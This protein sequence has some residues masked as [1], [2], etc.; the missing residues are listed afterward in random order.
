MSMDI[1]A[2]LGGPNE[3]GGN[4]SVVFEFLV[5][6]VKALW[7]KRH[8]PNFQA[9]L[10]RSL[11]G[12]LVLGWVCRAWRRFFA[13]AVEAWDGRVL[14]TPRPW[15]VVG[16]EPMVDQSV[17]DP[18]LYAVSQ[19]TIG[20]PT[21][22]RIVMLLPLVQIVEH[23]DDEAHRVVE[24]LRVGPCHPEIQATL[25]AIVTSPWSA[26][27]WNHFGGI[28]TGQYATHVD[29]VLGSFPLGF[30]YPYVTILTV[31][32]ARCT[33][34]EL[35]EWMVKSI[36][37]PP[38]WNRRDLS[39]LR[40]ALRSSIEA[41][42]DH[43][44][45]L[46]LDF[47][48]K[49][50][51]AKKASI[52]SGEYGW[53]WLFRVTL[54]RQSSEVAR[55]I[56]ELHGKEVVCS[57]DD[58]HLSLATMDIAVSKAILQSL[59]RARA[60]IDGNGT[61]SQRDSV[62]GSDA[63][64]CDLWKQCIASDRVDALEL[65]LSLDEGTGYCSDSDQ[66]EDDNLQR[67]G[68]QS[69]TFDREGFVSSQTGV[70]SSW[71]LWEEDRDHFSD[72]DPV[73]DKAEEEAYRSF[74]KSRRD[75][76][77]LSSRSLL[78][79]CQAGA[80]STVEF[81]LTSKDNGRERV[82]VT[83]AA[84]ME[85]ARQASPHILEVLLQH[86]QQEGTL[87]RHLMH[88]SAER[89]AGVLHE[90]CKPPNK[91]ME[92]KEACF[93]VI[94]ETLAPE[95]NPGLSLDEFSWFDERDHLPIHDATGSLQDTMARLFPADAL[96]KQLEIDTALLQHVGDIHPGGHSKA[97]I[98]KR[99]YVDSSC[100]VAVK[101][102]EK[103][104]MQEIKRELGIMS[105]IR[106]PYVVHMLGWCAL[107]KQNGDTAD[108]G[109][110]PGEYIGVVMNAYA[111]NLSS[112]LSNC[113]SDEKCI[114][115]RQVGAALKYL[116]AQ[117]PPITHGDIHPMNILLSRNPFDTDGDGIH[118]HAVLC[119][120]DL[121][122]IQ[123]TKAFEVLNL[124]LVTEVFRISSC[125]DGA[126][127]RQ[128][129]LLANDWL[130]FGFLLFT[131]VSSPRWDWRQ[132]SKYLVGRQK[133]DGSLLRAADAELFLCLP[134]GAFAVIEEFAVSRFGPR[135]QSNRNLDLIPELLDALTA[136][137]WKPFSASHFIDDDSFP[138][139][140]L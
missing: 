29:C 46:L 140:P 39:H 50:P 99:S 103:A 47:L 113:L 66:D 71:S 65:L 1:M 49:H 12:V 134:S 87:R 129:F 64:W 130:L 105:R 34:S 30:N 42:R 20:W 106:F 18:V 35:L 55:K 2:A 132:V 107:E 26:S 85:A 73:V 61:S 82:R 11:R 90:L 92:D 56:L 23:V 70:D 52:A 13:N 127:E 10:H 116:H 88:G 95:K 138:S 111:C 101:W 32:A 54:Q 15:S 76:S 89:K 25:V 137:E 78:L 53:T 110:T 98:E 83:S 9:R 91:K 131:V 75:R 45:L 6:N 21:A 72:R 121:S 8:A 126:V 22:K 3:S 108:D 51:A 114:W 79:A 133:L 124:F 4:F 57:S 93:R 62:L 122:S 37:P 112:V 19:H 63:R 60:N 40:G 81:L 139:T 24:M 136:L 38:P 67:S 94:C 123:G 125:P 17:C 7:E 118:A 43:N 128:D 115:M 135:I 86:A 104:R 36:L 102:Y 84:L 69:T 96:W 80:H 14:R 41:N 28:S 27:D 48:H 97:F 16:N 68:V 31:A 33:S 74:L 59:C 44:S 77:V 100:E 117:K 109:R 119:D 58:L 120:F 5:G